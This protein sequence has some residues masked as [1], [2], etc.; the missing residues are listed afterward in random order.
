[1]KKYFNPY[2]LVIFLT[3]LIATNNCFPQ[4]LFKI[5]EHGKIGFIDSTGRIVIKPKFAATGEFS[6]GL[7]PVRLKGYYGFID[8][9][10]NYVIK[11][12]YD[13]ATEFHEGFA[14][15]YIDS[16]PYYINK[17]GDKLF[18]FTVKKISNFKNGRALIKTFSDKFGLIDTNGNLILD[19][20]Y[21]EIYP[22]YDEQ[23]VIRTFEP[24]YDNT[25][26]GVVD[27]DGKLIVP[28]GLY[29]DIRE[30]NEGFSIVMIKSKD[31][32]N[33]EIYRKGF[34]NSKG[35]LIYRMVDSSRDFSDHR[36][37]DGF[38]RTY[39]IKYEITEGGISTS[40][41][42]HN[43]NLLDTNGHLIFSDSNYSCSNLSY[44]R[45]F[46]EPIEHG[47]G[48][49]LYDKW[50]NK[51]SND[52]YRQIYSS[53]Y[54]GGPFVNGYAMV[55]DSLNSFK[56]IDTSGNIISNLGASYYFEYSFELFK[57]GYLKY[58]KSENVRGI[59]L[60]NIYGKILT[61]PI[62]DAIDDRY[63][64]GLLKVVSI[65]SLKG[66]L[67]YN[68]KFVWKE[69]KPNNKDL[70]TLDLD[71]KLDFYF[72][73]SNTGVY[74][75][76]KIHNIDELNEEINLKRNQISLF[77]DINDN[78]KFNGK[79][80]G[81]K[82]YIINSTKDFIKII[83]EDY[84]I[85]LILQALD[86]NN[87]W[88]DIQYYQHSWCGNS[89]TEVSFG[90]LSFKTF[91]APRFNGVFKTK[92][93]AKLTYK[94]N[95]YFWNRIDVYS[96]IIEGYINPAQLWRYPDYEIEIG[97]PYNSNGHH[98]DYFLYNIY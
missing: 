19:T 69:S 52:K 64:N 48:F 43:I 85:Y 24:E 46:L 37:Y 9:T 41:D 59:G 6:E 33:L 35:E 61:N 29:D 7:A 76:F 88:K 82:L 91:T 68:G 32:T 56:I 40:S 58:R 62:F 50:G 5:Y 27:R 51:I 87:E 73:F 75:S 12:Q 4:S 49:S 95:L 30:F 18:N 8:T 25:K 14:I 79:Y 36:F 3:F 17:S 2:Y 21:R 60:M 11:P 42:F 63:H 54:E 72:A 39:K 96:N 67:D 57:Q 92:I 78:D 16:L 34:I 13:F 31:S 55:I 90:P 44:N 45:I 15:A 94:D 47:F 81:Y 65:D 84:Y 77:L 26:I 93:R 66:Y 98:S 38:I 70:D 97:N 23:I 71:F 10:G 89:Y 74:E 28:F 22:Y 53:S 83:S 20:N 1:M 80:T 86:E